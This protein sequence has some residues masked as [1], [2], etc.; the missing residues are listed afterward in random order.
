M[1]LFALI[2]SIIMLSAAFGGTVGPPATADG[3]AVAMS[4]CSEC[5]PA[6]D[7]AFGHHCQPGCMML[8]ALLPVF[9][10]VDRAERMADWTGIGI[11][12]RAGRLTAPPTGPPK[13][14]S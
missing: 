8:A 1:R 10:K 11:Q 5:D 9:G 3:M 6:H 4:D 13:T 2:F 7:R 12:A 14:L